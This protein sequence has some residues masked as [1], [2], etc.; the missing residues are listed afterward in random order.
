LASIVM[1][2]ARLFTKL[3]DSETKKKCLNE[4]GKFWAAERKDVL[5]VK[6]HPV[7]KADFSSTKHDFICLLGDCI[8]T[9]KDKPKK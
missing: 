5:N 2:A 8:N 1:V 9:I 4:V 6:D 7:T 3:A